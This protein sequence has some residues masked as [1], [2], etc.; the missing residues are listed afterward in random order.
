L[1][2]QPARQVAVSIRQL[3]RAPIS[4]KKSH[5]VLQSYAGQRHP[6]QLNQITPPQGLRQPTRIMPRTIII[7]Q[8]ENRPAIAIRHEDV[9]RHQV[10]VDES[11][12]MKLANKASQTLELLPFARQQNFTLTG[13]EQT[14]QKYVE[15]FRIDAPG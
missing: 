3:P 13:L 7:H 9:R 10:A 1:A 11:L 6:I 8:I 14:M 4:V 2:L 5:T 15:W 12:K